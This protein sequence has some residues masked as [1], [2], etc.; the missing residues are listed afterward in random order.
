MDLEKTMRNAF[1]AFALLVLTALICVG[2]VSR[3]T[4]AAPADSS[5]ES[6]IRALIQMQADAWNRG[7]IDAFMTA[8]WKSDETAFVGASG[9]TRGWQAVLDRYHKNYPDRAAMGYLKFSNLEIHLLCPDAAFA[10]GQ[11][12]LQRE[13]DKPAGIFTLDFK[14]F[15]EGWRIVVDHTTAFPAITH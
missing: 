4:T 13:N 7:D 2:P 11:F 8:Y 14:K 12:Q 6:Q 3:D 9:L 15:A 10:I 1:R 5:P